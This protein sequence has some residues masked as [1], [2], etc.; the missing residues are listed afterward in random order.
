M[1]ARKG[2]LIGCGVM[3][4]LGVAAAIAAVL[5]FG[6]LMDSMDKVMI[7]PKVYEAARVGQTESEVRAKLP[8]GDSFMKEAF[9]QDGPAQ[10]AGSTCS[11]YTADLDSEGTAET[12]Y[13]FCFADGKLAEK[14]S[15]RMK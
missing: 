3:L 9:K 7:D 2:C 4:V 10:P 12:V 14:V 8:S 5:G 15:Y 13:R 1:A 11:W 6:K